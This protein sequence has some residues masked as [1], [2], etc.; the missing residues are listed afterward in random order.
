MPRPN[1]PR[2]IDKERTL[3]R[4]IVELRDQRGFTNESLARRMT[5]AG[6]PIRDSA[7]YKIEKGTPPR[8][9]TVDELFGFAAAFEMPVTDLLIWGSGNPLREST[10]PR[11]LQDLEVLFQRFSELE[12][13]AEKVRGQRA[14]VLQDLKD[15]LHESRDVFESFRELMA[16]PD[17]DWPEFLKWSGIDRIIGAR[18]PRRSAKEHSHE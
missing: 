18:K 4:R 8:R 7:I 2:T 3:A 9:I 5:D 1:Q 11:H 12:R 13:E 10:V 15:V 14:R 6:C 17:Y 16:S